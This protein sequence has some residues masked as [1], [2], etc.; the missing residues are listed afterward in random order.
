MTGSGENLG[1]L[2]QSRDRTKPSPRGLPGPLPTASGLR[3]RPGLLGK[4]RNPSPCPRPPPASRPTRPGAGPRAGPGAGAGA[5]AA[6]GDGDPG[7]RPPAE[8]AGGQ[9]APRSR[10]RAPPRPS[11]PPGAPPSPSRRAHRGAGGGAARRPEPRARLLR[12]RARPPRPRRPRRPRRPASGG[13]SPGATPASAPRG[14]RGFRA[15]PGRPAS[16]S[17]PA[18]RTEPPPRPGLAAAAAAPRAL[19]ASR[20]RTH[21][22]ARADHAGAPRTLART[23]ARTHA[24][25]P[26]AEGATPAAAA[27]RPPPAARRPPPAVGA[28]PRR[29]LAAA[30][31]SRRGA[32]RYAFHLRGPRGC[33]QDSARFTSGGDAWRRGGPEGTRWFQA[34]RS[35]EVE[36]KPR[37]VL[38]SQKE[39]PL[40]Q[41][42]LKTVAH[43]GR[44]AVGLR[45]AWLQH[46]HVGSWKN[47]S[48]STQVLNSQVE[49]TGSWA[50]LQLVAAIGTSPITSCFTLE[51]S[52]N[53]IQ[54][55]FP[56][57][58]EV[59]DPRA[60]HQP[61]TEMSYVNPPTII[62][63]CNAVSPLHCV[64]IAI[65]CNS[66]GDHS[67]GWRWWMLAWEVL[68]M[69]GTISYEHSWGLPDLSFCREPE[70]P[71]KEEQATVEMA[72]TKEEFQGEWTVSAPEF[73][74][75]QPGVAGCPKA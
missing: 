70:E 17:P 32:L 13:A 46:H 61:L 42:Y 26:S 22:L 48:G 2:E 59:T 24:R 44:S 27:S 72:M 35:C 53:Q 45:T 12:E 68:H 64:G 4:P 40:A 63:L 58:L 5:G 16:R 49:S 28:R 10:A 21:G 51:T 38:Q 11:A 50:T 23:H 15:A 25:A 34:A 19:A 39:A 14:L 20:S 37:Q 9:R 57:S 56:V 33:G 65:P 29:L 36:K 3:P 41:C 31:R 73:T 30:S 7:P 60:D 1:K 47:S 62:T 74:A 43:S 55:A 75:I 52:T 69:P 8:R 71:E 67:V 18:R 6:R 66:K 54:A